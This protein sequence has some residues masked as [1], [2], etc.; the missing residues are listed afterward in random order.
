MIFS[1][2]KEQ[3]AGPNSFSEGLVDVAE[4]DASSDTAAL[5]R[6]GRRAAGQH[7]RTAA[8]DGHTD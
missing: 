8:P 2:G 7:Q 3:V 4:Q 6:L 1:L 5:H